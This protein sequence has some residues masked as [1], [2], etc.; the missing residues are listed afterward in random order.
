MLSLIYH[1]RHGNEVMGQR[2]SDNKHVPSE[3]TS[4]IQQPSRSAKCQVMFCFNTCRLE[5]LRFLSYSQ[6]THFNFCLYE[7]YNSSEIPRGVFSFS[8]WEWPVLNSQY[9][10]KLSAKLHRGEEWK[11]QSGGWAHVGTSGRQISAVL[12]II[13]ESDSLLVH[14]NE[15]VNYLN[16]SSPFNEIAKSPSCSLSI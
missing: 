5:G 15:D 11:E 2:P 10:L 4:Y 16:S 7:L 6:I 8:L 3:D 13:W 1:V 9:E 14:F 12:Y